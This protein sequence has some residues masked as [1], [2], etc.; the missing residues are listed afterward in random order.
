MS[1]KNPKKTIF[2]RLNHRKDLTFIKLNQKNDSVPLG[3]A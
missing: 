2:I 1:V 3:S